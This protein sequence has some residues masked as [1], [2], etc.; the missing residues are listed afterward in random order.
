MWEETRKKESKRQTLKAVQQGRREAEER[1]TEFRQSGGVK[2]CGGVLGSARL[3]FRG[4]PTNHHHTSQLL[5]LE[6]ID[7][8]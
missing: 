3:C 4:I 6:L 8:F 2:E 1:G 7:S 5:S